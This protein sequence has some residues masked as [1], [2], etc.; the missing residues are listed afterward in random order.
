[1]RRIVV[2]GASLAGLRAGEALR[3]E[4]FDGELTMLGAEPHLPYNR[5][6]LSKELLAGEVERSAVDLLAP[7]ELRA[8]WRLG[9]AARRLDLRSRRIE[10]DDESHVEFDGLVIATGVRPRMLPRSAGAPRRGVFALR[11]I[12]D[13]VRLA[14]ALRSAGSVA[15]VGAGFIGCEVAA[16][17]R[18]LGRDVTLIDV[19]PAPLEP[20]LGAAL[21]DWLAG[22]HR[23][24][25]VRLAL[26][27]PVEAL[28]GQE[29]L[30]AVRL[31]DG[32]R[33]DADL[34]VVG[35][36]TEACTE[37]LAG[38][39]IALSDGVL[40]DETLAAVG[41]EGVVAAG[42]VARWP[43][44]GGAPVRVEHWSNAVD[45]GFAAARTLLHGAAAGPLQTLPSFWSDQHGVRI[46]SIGLPGLSDA[47]ATLIEGGF[48][49]GGFILAY[50]RR[51]RMVAAVSVGLPPRRLARL[52]A[53][54]ARAEP[55]PELSSPAPVG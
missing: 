27:S 47:P 20:R 3:A 54:V 48:E 22:L 10:L 36:G 45:H 4:G 53:A 31:A 26:G 41:V 51:G 37:W 32:R 12:D 39:G 28:E 55:M 9:V 19:A 25:G 43:Y 18:A 14:A 23:E 35:L 50:A 2:V 17:A 1:M 24:R 29:R 8:Q 13:S 5:P 49:E 15:V 52:R 42:D 38:S 34:A 30:V 7:D 46:Q 11:T 40:C 6:P 44:A 21:G 16:T 33:I